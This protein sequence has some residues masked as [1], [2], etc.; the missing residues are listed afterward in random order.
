MVILWYLSCSWSRSLAGR[1]GIGAEQD[2][3]M[4]TSQSTLSKLPACP[5]FV[6]PGQTMMFI[7]LFEWSCSLSASFIRF[8]SNI[9]PGVAN[10]HRKLANCWLISSSS[11][12]AAF[13]ISWMSF[14]SPPDSE[15]WCWMIACH[16]SR[17]AL[18]RRSSRFSTHPRAPR[19]CDSRISFVVVADQVWKLWRSVAVGL[20]R[21]AQRFSECCI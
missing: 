13:R 14:F 12:I 2:T 1:G 11:S 21:S 19:F 7:S 9:S 15:E 5:R 8:S 3:L 10:S 17:A 6:I 20:T 16:I 4:G 18:S